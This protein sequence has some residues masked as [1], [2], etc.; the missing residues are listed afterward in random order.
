MSEIVFQGTS[1]LSLD[2]KGRI[3]VPARHRAD[4]V[5]L[6]GNQLTLTKHSAGCLLMF[7]RPSWVA[8]RAKLLELPISADGWRRLYLGS[9]VDVEVDSGERVLVAPEL[10]LA[11]GLTKDVLLVGNGQRLEIWDAERHARQEA[12]VMASEIPP[13]IQGFVF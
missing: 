8:F 13:S 7:P 4:L 2:V 3:T 5:A 10:R 11:A 9:A 12:Q 1:A 6:C